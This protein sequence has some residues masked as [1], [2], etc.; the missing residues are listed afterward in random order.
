MYTIAVRA[1]FDA[2]HSVRIGTAPRE[3]PHAHEWVVEAEVAADALDRDGLVMD[4]VRL[5]GVVQDCIAG[6]HGA[7]L[8]ELPEFAELN[9]TAE[10]VARTIYGRLDG[11]LGEDRATLAGVTVWEAEGCRATYRPR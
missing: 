1:R 5:R 8:N 6:F 2:S 4:F 9:P 11:Q 7:L 3:A 10:N